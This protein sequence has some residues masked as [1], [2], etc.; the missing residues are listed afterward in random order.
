M[1]LWEKMAEEMRRACQNQPRI[2]SEE[3][4]RQRQA[5]KSF[6]AY[7]KSAPKPKKH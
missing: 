1:K 3:A 2:T 6:T 5:I 7:D 4:A